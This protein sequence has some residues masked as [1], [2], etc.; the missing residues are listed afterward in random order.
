MVVVLLLSLKSKL[1]SIKSRAEIQFV[2]E[3]KTEK[4]PWKHNTEGQEEDYKIL[5]V[6]GRSFTT[7]DCSR[8]FCFLKILLPWKSQNKKS[9]N[10]KKIR[11][12]DDH[13][14]G[15]E[16]ANPLCWLLPAG[17]ELK[18]DS[19]IWENLLNKRLAEHCKSLPVG[20]R[21]KKTS[22]LQHTRTNQL[23]NSPVSSLFAITL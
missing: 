8:R 11:V 4:N 21:E 13:G 18:H 10:I 3:K 15:K 6:L 5:P 19:L 23:L 17:S 9:K 1:L 7:A 14:H 12:A 22:H 2:R 16:K 20:R